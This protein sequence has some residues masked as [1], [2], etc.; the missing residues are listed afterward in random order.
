MGKAHSASGRAA[1]IRR[2]LAGRSARF[3]RDE[4]GALIIFGLYLF[5]ALMLIGGI[6]VD[7]MRYEA[8]R[9]RVQSTLDRAIL[10]AASLGQTAKPEDV[11]NDYFA[12][13]GL[14]DY[15]TSI[16]VSVDALNAKSVTATAEMELPTMFM[17]LVG[18]DSL[19]APAA[20]TAEDRIDN[21]EISLVL[22]VSGSMSETVTGSKPSIT[23]I[24]ALQT[25]AK[26]FV[27]TMFDTI[28]G[29]D[30]PP[31]KLAISVV[32]YNQQV[33]IG[34][35]LSPY[36]NLTNEHSY[37]SCVDFKGSDFNTPELSTTASL[38]R[39]GYMDVRYTA[40]KL[41]FTE[42]FLEDE[43]R[44]I[45]AFSN[46]R[47]TL[48]TKIEKFE[49]NGAT[50]SE[51]GAKWGFALL[52]PSAQTVV[53]QMI[54]GNKIGSELDK[55]PYDYD[56]PVSMKIMVLMTDGDNTEHYQLNSGYRSG[57]SGL[58]KVTYKSGTK[59]LTKYYFY[60]AAK[61]TKPYYDYS[62]STWVALSSLEATPVPM[63][64]PEVWSTMSVSYFANTYVKPAMGSTTASNLITNAKTMIESEKDDRIKNVCAAAKEKGVIVFSIAFQA[65]P[66]GKAVMKSCASTLGHYYEVGSNGLN[67]AEAFDSIATHIRQLRLTQ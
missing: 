50:S 57:Q 23:K 26:G 49:A 41:T 13:A 39:A 48:K 36:Y 10:A 46:N 16:T 4:S 8:T 25:A 5:I 24:K 55:R 29:P 54:A 27:D 37:T 19:T 18:V 1:A 22:D 3:A 56:D 43:K 66:L 64:Y 52:D 61:G 21:V 34:P 44:N 30:A 51:I 60:S 31:G 12:K 35:Q 53:N 63:S 20:G 33:V 67:I 62:T 45:L 65:P 17:R 58:N 59:T 11:V 14:L 9:A 28:Q 32:P 42:C 38:Q 47:A 6:S 2:I 15:L 40:S 7:M